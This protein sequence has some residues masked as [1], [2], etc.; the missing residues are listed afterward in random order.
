[1]GKN[2]KKSLIALTAIVT[3]NLGL[4]VAQTPTYQVVKN[5]FSGLAK[6]LNLPL[7]AE[8]PDNEGFK[9]GKDKQLKELYNLTLMG[10]DPFL[11][12]DCQVEIKSFRKNDFSI[13]ITYLPKG[14]NRSKIP[15][16]YDV[17]EQRRGFIH[18]DLWEKYQTQMVARNKEFT[19]V[20]K[21]KDQ[22][23][24]VSPP[25]G[26]PMLMDTVF[27]LVGGLE[28][29]IVFS[30]TNSLGRKEVVFQIARFQSMNP[31]DLSQTPPPPINEVSL[32]SWHNNACV[33]TVGAR[34]W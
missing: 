19:A 16:I 34:F 26:A 5:F 29:T 21:G 15:S 31:V 12:R 9:K 25:A 30:Q 6:D 33:T 22:V 2:M 3:L 1:M 11:E 27:P 13:L 4:A 20:L 8:F 28:S 18:G 17:V 24:F 10:F 7:P 23:K 32:D 14:R